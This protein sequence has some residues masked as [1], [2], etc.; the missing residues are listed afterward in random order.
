MLNDIEKGYA[1]LD[2]IYPKFNDDERSLPNH[3]PDSGEFTE[4]ADVSI[5]PFAFWVLQEGDP[6]GYGEVLSPDVNHRKSDQTTFAN[7]TRAN[8]RYASDAL[9][10]ASKDC[11]EHVLQQGVIVAMPYALHDKKAQPDGES[12]KLVSLL[13]FTWKGKK[14]THN[15]LITADGIV[16]KAVESIQYRALANFFGYHLSKGKD[17]VKKMLSLS[18]PHFTALMARLLP[19]R[20]SICDVEDLNEVLNKMDYP[21]R[22]KDTLAPVQAFTHFASLLRCMTR[23][24]F[25]VLEG[26]HR[27]FLLNRVYQGY[28]EKSTVPL[29]YGNNNTQKLDPFPKT[30]TLAKHLDVRILHSNEKNGFIT[31]KTITRAKKYSLEAQKAKMNVVQTLLDGAIRQAMTKFD[32]TT[33]LKTG[34]YYKE[35]LDKKKEADR[36][37]MAATLVIEELFQESMNPYRERAA[38]GITNKEGALA[39]FASGTDGKLLNQKVISAPTPT[40]KVNANTGCYP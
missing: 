11:N 27:S 31:N 36:V 29:Q 39:H 30:G 8:D 23:I 2:I 5:S 22:Y 3:A 28:N 33:E 15:R 37:K 20:K 34:D 14:E 6:M 38:S 21:Y 10:D 1:N 13:S 7:L 35:V 9:F 24:R 40:N 32:P 18:D 19:D 17:E 4:R 16:A 26:G 25:A 12:I